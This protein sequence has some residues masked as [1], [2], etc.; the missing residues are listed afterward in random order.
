MTTSAKIG[1]GA[2]VVG[3]LGATALG[4][5][6]ATRDKS[7]P[8]R[9]GR[10]DGV[11]VTAVDVDRMQ[12][13]GRRATRKTTRKSKPSKSHRRAAPPPPPIEEFG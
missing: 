3:V 11:R 6:A 5:Y 7:Q 1:V 4:I 12:A 8:R 9:A 10:A 13:E 2:A